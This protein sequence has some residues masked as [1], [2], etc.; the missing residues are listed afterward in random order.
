MDPEF[1]TTSVPEQDGAFPTSVTSEGR[2]TTD[3]MSGL[4]STVAEYITNAITT[5]VAPMIS[6]FSGTAEFHDDD[7]AI[8]HQDDG[9]AASTTP[10]VAHHT[11]ARSD[12][13][14]T[15]PMPRTSYEEGSFSTTSAELK[16]TTSG[17]APF[18][19]LT[20]HKDPSDISTE[21]KDERLT[22]RP[23]VEEEF[24]TSTTGPAAASTDTAPTTEATATVV[25]QDRGTVTLFPGE[26]MT[27][28]AISTLSPDAVATTP[29]TDETTEAAGHISTG[30]V[31]FSTTTT[32][33]ERDEV[34]TT[35]AAWPGIVDIFATTTSSPSVNKPTLKL[36]LKVTGEIFS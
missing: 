4:L 18:D 19:E 27:M 23:A 36:H 25:D 22:T 20:T 13:R 12:V 15:T 21:G 32:S 10:E 26:T 9:H 1:T 30:S 14:S 34:P 33:G 29:S 28:G 5:T 35:T 17:L 31:S 16:T 3:G 7:A 8:G 2:T 24:V 11:T 6:T